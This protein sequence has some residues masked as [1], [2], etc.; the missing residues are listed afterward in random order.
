M[1]ATGQTART[2][3]EA[4]RQRPIIRRKI[5][6][7]VHR[8]DKNYMAIICGDTGSGKSEF[9]LRLC[10]LLDPDFDESR[11]AFTIKEFTELVQE[12]HPPG[13]AILF[14]EVGIALSHATHYDDDQIK[15]NHILQSWREQ[16]RILI[17]TAPHIRLVHKSD[18][19]LL[20]AQMDMQ[21]IDRRRHLATARYRNIQQNTDTGELYK[22]YPRLRNPDTGRREKA[23]HLRLYKP[24]PDLVEPYT[25][26]KLAF[27]D[28]LNEDVHEQVTPEEGADL[29]PQDV[30]D[31]IK[32]EADLAEFVSIHGGH[33]RAYIDKD[34]IRAQFELSHNDAATVQKLLR[35]DSDVE[36]SKEMVA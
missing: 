10:Q 27:N 35:R 11:I 7:R 19:G 30:V 14:D 29:S 32:T 15:V 20:H 13:S 31:H 26:Q 6:D 4:V 5:W 1:S 25:E 17:M 9:G 23:K 24:S 36:V 22:K 8:E 3:P 21:D 18:R 16:N 33:N 34:L 28:Q 12:R 2:P